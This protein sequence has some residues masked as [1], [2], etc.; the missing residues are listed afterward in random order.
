MKEIRNGVLIVHGFQPLPPTPASSRQLTT[1]AT[2]L[3][4]GRIPIERGTP[5]KEYRMT[6]DY[7]TG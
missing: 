4:Q 1:D 2:C 5:N 7:G 6:L 3:I